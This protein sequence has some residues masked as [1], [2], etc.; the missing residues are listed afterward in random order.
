MGTTKTVSKAARIRELL[1]EGKSTREIADLLGCDPAY[2]RVAGRQRQKGVSSADER[3]YNKLYGVDTMADAWRIQSQRR[4]ANPVLYAR[5]LEQ[6]N[7]WK[8]R[9]R[10]AKASNKSC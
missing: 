2:V 6:S 8:R 5:H 4:Y 1:A 9:K 10:L 3:Y 7:A